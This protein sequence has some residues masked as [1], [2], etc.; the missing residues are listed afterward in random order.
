M[1][2]ALIIFGLIIFSLFSGV[3]VAT[4]FYS[5]KIEGVDTTIEGGGS[6]GQYLELKVFMNDDGM[7]F[8]GVVKRNTSNL[9][10]L[11][12]GEF[13]MLFDSEQEKANNL[14][15]IISLTRNENAV[16]IEPDYTLPEINSNW[17]DDIM[18][19]YVKYV[20][21]ENDDDPDNNN[22]AVVGPIK[23]KRTLLPNTGSLKINLFPDSITDEALWCIDDSCYTSGQQVSLVPGSYDIRFTAVDGKTAPADLLNFQIKRGDRKEINKTYSSKMCAVSVE[24]VPDV[25]RFKIYDNKYNMWSM[26]L[27]SGE[28]YP[29]LEIGTTQVIYESMSGWDAPITQVVN[30]TCDRIDTTKGVYCP[31]IPETIENV[32]ASKT[33]TQYVL[34]TWSDKS[35]FS[36]CGITYD[37][38]RAFID[39]SST[40]LPIA[41]DLTTNYYI[42][43][44]SEQNQQYYYFIRAKRNDY[45]AS[46]FAQNGALGYRKLEKVLNVDATDGMHI[47]KIIIRWLYDNLNVKFKILRSGTSDISLSK[48]IAQNITGNSFE[49]TDVISNKPYYY[50]I[51]VKNDFTWSANSDYDIGSS[52]L[53]APDD[54][55]IDN[56]DLNKSANPYIGIQISLPDDATSCEVKKVT[57]ARSARTLDNTIKQCP[58]RNVTINGIH[59]YDDCGPEYCQYELYDV[60]CMNSFGS[61]ETVR[62]KGKACIPSPKITSI[63]YYEKVGKIEIKWFIDYYA[64][65][66]QYEIYRSNSTDPDS[67]ELVTT[68]SANSFTDIVWGCY[69]Y[70]V[71]ALNSNTQ[72]SCYS[73]FTEP[74]PGCSKNCNFKLQPENIFLTYESN[75]VSTDLI[76]EADPL[77]EW[78]VRSDA[79]WISNINPNNGSAS[80]AINADIAQIDDSETNKV[81]HINIIDIHDVIRSTLT[82]TRT[83]TIKLKIV[84]NEGGKISVNGASPVVLYEQDH[85]INDS[86]SIEAIPD[87]NYEFDRFEGRS[88]SSNTCS[89]NILKSESINVYFKTEK[90]NL[91]IL[92]ND[93]DIVQFVNSQ[94]TVIKQVVIPFYESIDKGTN[95]YLKAVNDCKSGYLWSGDCGDLYDQT[96]SLL[97]NSDKTVN[98]YCRPDWE[99]YIYIFKPDGTS[100]LINLGLANESSVNF[101]S[102]DA[103]LFFLDEDYCVTKYKEDIRKQGLNENIWYIGVKV[104]DEPVSLSWWFANECVYGDNACK[105]DFMQLREGKSSMGRVFV[106]ELRDQYTPVTISGQGIKFFTLHKSKEKFPTI[107][108]AKRGNSNP[109]IKIGLADEEKFAS[110]VPYP[111]GQECSIGLKY[112]N[113]DYISIYQENGNEEYVFDFYVNPKGYDTEDSE[114]V[115]CTLSWDPASFDNNYNYYL[116]D[117]EEQCAI[118]DMKKTKDFVV[119]GVNENYFYQILLTHEDIP[120][121]RDCNENPFFTKGPDVEVSNNSGEQV[122]Y[123]WA[124]NISA[125]SDRESGQ[126]VSF[127]LIG[128]DNQKILSGPPQITPEGTLIFEPSS[129]NSGTSNVTIVLNDDGTGEY[130]EPKRIEVFKITTTNESQCSIKLS[131]N[132]IQSYDLDPSTAVSE[133]EKDSEFMVEI[134]LSDLENTNSMIRGYGLNILFDTD[135]IQVLE[136]SAGPIFDFEGNQVFEVGENE[137]DHLNGKVTYN[138]ASMTPT[139]IGN[140]VL[141]V[142]KCK[143]LLKPGSTCI[144]FDEVELIDPNAQNIQHCKQNQCLDIAMTRLYIDPAAITLGSGDT[145]S[146]SIMLTNVVDFSGPEK[147]TIKYNPNYLSALSV[148]D[149]PFLASTGGQLMPVQKIIVKDRKSVV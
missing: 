32:E 142:L 53:A 38:W 68:T 30:I 8:R 103:N 63:D 3:A 108:S 52:V 116:Y 123:N 4:D 55:K 146:T 6:L 29:D 27:K 18:K 36:E 42:D 61:S 71:R 149:G 145:F 93:G 34:L 23:I 7:T 140:N 81:G 136:M 50:W 100:E 46:P 110:L 19:I 117:E 72:D 119:T 124:T 144:S 88:S 111:M 127:E 60:V 13:S 125:G 98:I 73:E 137:I 16:G 25:G 24:I 147:L 40:A 138:V 15:K 75:S 31:H 148:I 99:G 59:Y 101:A 58:G 90:V 126:N 64:T 113:V 112:N 79:Q 129:A 122:I 28:I 139:E 69:Y 102:D 17:T 104:A 105:E 67:F 92:G 106:S 39:D 5:Y 47:G 22:F 141:L 14:L 76:V 115:S 35:A 121:S 114:S 48:V 57:L 74:V 66:L 118:A 83:P 37:V 33:N 41:T 80:I 12:P 84:A 45:E 96:I 44:D 20:E 26:W 107:I 135:Y 128:Y 82:I 51:A 78:E 49:D 77:C 134:R 2:K 132:T 54:I 87:A 85:N 62:I 10:I 65:G 94:G 131:V 97:M 109:W 89:F 86:I 130:C 70:K 120:V 11:K 95:V 133:L 91:S 9:D 1:K 21:D 56:C 143:S 43:K